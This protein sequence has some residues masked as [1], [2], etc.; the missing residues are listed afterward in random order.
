MLKSNQK[1]VLKIKSDGNITNANYKTS[2]TA[3]R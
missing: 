2:I 1:L 3:N